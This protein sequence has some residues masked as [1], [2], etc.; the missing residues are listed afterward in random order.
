M[1]IRRYVEIPMFDI[2]AFS[3]IFFAVSFESLTPYVLCKFLLF[4]TIILILP[5][6]CER[7]TIYLLNVNKDCQV[8]SFHLSQKFDEPNGF[9]KD[10][11]TADIS[12][13]T[14]ISSCMSKFVWSPCI[15]KDGIRHQSNFIRADYCVLDFDDG[16]MSLSQAIN[17]FCDMKCIIGTTKSHQKEKHGIVCDRFRVLLEWEEPI[18]DLRIYRFNMH[19]FMKNY[20]CDKKCKDGG[21][22][23]YPC[24]DIV[25]YSKEGYVE[26]VNKRVPDRFEVYS[27]PNPVFQHLLIPPSVFLKRLDRNYK[28]DNRN[29]AFY[30]FAKDC[31]KIGLT[32]D[33]IIQAFKS[34]HAFK[35]LPPLPDREIYITLMSARKS[36]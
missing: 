16:E 15:W 8:I 14:R 10:F 9:Y 29:N 27:D 13:F 28:A 4:L 36:L 21:R 5:L 3:I 12:D 7:G 25:F 2:F 34:S 26:A 6:C 18:T 35:S 33:A 32:D 24:N 20:P 17:T 22:F 11:K 31:V 1:I 19:N 23:F 30:G